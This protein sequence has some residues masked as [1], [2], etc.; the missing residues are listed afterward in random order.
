MPGL[1]NRKAGAMPRRV[2]IPVVLVLALVAFELPLLVRLGSRP[3]HQAAPAGV[4]RVATPAPRAAPRPR[5]AAAKLGRAAPLPTL[6]RPPRRVPA[7]RPQVVARAPVTV[8]VAPTPAPQPAATAPPPSSDVPGPAPAPAPAP[9][10]DPAPARS[11]PAPSVQFDDSGS[12][13]DSGGG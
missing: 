10:S 4:A 2:T 12:F 6:R 9:P 13:D 1:P 11:A 7:R 8:A 3:D 5:L